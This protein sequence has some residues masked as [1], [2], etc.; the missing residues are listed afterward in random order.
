MIQMRHLPGRSY[1]RVKGNI[2]VYNPNVKQGDSYAA[3][4]I[5]NGEEYKTNAINT[6]WMVFENLY[7][8][9]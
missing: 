7:L 9:I 6:G 8:L 4:Q 2:A 1:T 5:T 3:I